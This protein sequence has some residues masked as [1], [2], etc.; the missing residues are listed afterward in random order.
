MLASIVAVRGLE[1]GEVLSPERYDPRRK[2]GSSKRLLSDLVD[3]VRDSL[4][5]EKASATTN[6]VVLDTG[7]ADRGM[8]RAIGPAQ[9]ARKVGSVKKFVKPGDVIISRLRP[10]LRQVAW[11][12]EVVPMGV[13][14]ACSTEFFVLRAKTEGESVAF[15]VP[16]LLS[17]PVH[18]VLCAAQEGGHHP[19]F[20]Q[21]T[22]E[23]LSIP[24]QVFKK[25]GEISSRVEAA[26]HAAR[27]AEA[28][29]VAE[30]ERLSS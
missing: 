24:D 23:G 14:L 28:R 9:P 22:L 16:F 17:A 13:Q 18:R 8:L 20:N 2:L 1:I 12:D 4:E 25:R 30:V 3:V 5:P 15:L 7:H 11:V 19:R 26:V 27:E 21:Q 10:Y 29:M 6:V